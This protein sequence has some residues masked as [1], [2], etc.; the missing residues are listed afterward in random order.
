MIQYGCYFAANYKE[1]L[2]H[3]HFCKK[4]LEHFKGRQQLLS[5][6]KEKL[7]RSFL[8]KDKPVFMV[9]N[10]NIECFVK[11]RVGRRL[12]LLKITCE[13]TSYQ[14]LINTK[15]ISDE[16]SVKKLFCDPP[17]TH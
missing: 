8:M 14:L 13:V 3:L 7:S 4:K 15:W 6:V 11:C 10:R 17:R 9:S 1:V 12:F 2:H 16:L 5:V